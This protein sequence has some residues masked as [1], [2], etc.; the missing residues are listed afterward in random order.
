M[1]GMIHDTFIEMIDRKII[2][3]Y[4]IVTLIAVVI[5]LS[6]SSFSGN[7]EING[8][9][10]DDPFSGIIE[11]AAIKGLGSH[12]G[13]MIFLAV[14]ASAG[15]L[16]NMLIRGRAEYYLSKPL[17]RTSFYLNKYFSIWLVYGGMTI[18]CALISYMALY[19]SH[20]FSSTSVFYLFAFSLI[21]YFVWLSITLFAGIVFGTTAL[22]MMTAFLVFVLQWLFGFHEMFGEFVNSKI[23]KVV[24]DWL[25]YIFPKTGEMSDLAENLAMGQDVNSWMPLWST[26]LFSIVLIIVTIVIFK[27]KDY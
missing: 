14:F 25:Y 8:Q 23:M 22:S 1:R 6:A 10:Q 15:L 2:W 18:V 19:F 9:I 3:M 26:L 16:P 20:D 13:F 7:I 5:I 11:T 27:R 21:E 4:A 17:S 12:I 24:A